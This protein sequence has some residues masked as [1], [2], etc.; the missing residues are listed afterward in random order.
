MNLT[1]RELAILSEIFALMAE[2]TNEELM[3]A[4]LG[5]HL[6]ELLR[7]D[8]FGSYVWDENDATF[9]RR[10]AIN[11]SDDNLSDYETYYQHRDTVTPKLQSHHVAVRVSDVIGQRKLVRTELFNDFLRQDGLYWGLNVYAWVG[12]RNL[13]DLRVWRARGQDDFSDHELGLLELIRPAFSAALNRIQITS[14]TL[15]IENDLK[16]PIDVLLALSKREREVVMLVV[17]GL[18]DKEIARQLNVSYT[19]V[20][21]H[22]DRA[23]EKLGVGNRLKLARMLLA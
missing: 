2:S 20:R 15:A 5:V 11:L 1:T 10:T 14:R 7:G 8:Y 4:S 22:L 18:S 19:T 6:L 23:Y 9:A 3:R 12:G 13:G 21:T 16:Q 17:D